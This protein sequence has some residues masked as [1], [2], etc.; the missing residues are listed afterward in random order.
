ML[1]EHNGEN[2]EVRRK[3]ISVRIAARESNELSHTRSYDTLQT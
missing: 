2:A 3:H 1:I